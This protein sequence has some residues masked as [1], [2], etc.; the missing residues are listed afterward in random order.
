MAEQPR[1]DLRGG[2]APYGQRG[3]HHDAGIFLD[4]RA[5]VGLEEPLR[6][7][8]GRAQAEAAHHQEHQIELERNFHP[9]RACQQDD[10]NDG[11]AA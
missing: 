4:I 11:P 7:G 2:V 10:I 9:V 3:A 1:L 6:D 8:V 5:R